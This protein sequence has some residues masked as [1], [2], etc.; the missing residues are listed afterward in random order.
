MG[1]KE[2]KEMRVHM[3]TPPRRPTIHVPKEPYPD[4]RA[5]RVR[6]DLA[7]VLGKQEELEREAE[8]RSREVLRK[9]EAAKPPIQ[10]FIE[11]IRRITKQQPIRHAK[12]QKSSSLS[13]RKK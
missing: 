8:L 12:R 3:D 2:R 1:R 9:E 13:S 5:A 7:R 10:K 6:K 4:E 11:R